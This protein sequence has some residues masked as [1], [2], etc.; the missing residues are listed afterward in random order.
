MKSQTQ[1]VII[2]AVLG[3]L[4]GGSFAWIA[5]QNTESGEKAGAKLGPSDYFQLGIGVLTLARQFGS[6]IQRS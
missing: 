3:A 2:G 6:M 5:S 1:S 4:L